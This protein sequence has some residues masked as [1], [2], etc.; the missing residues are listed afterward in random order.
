MVCSL[1]SIYFGSPQLGIQ[2]KRLSK[3]L[4]Y[5]SREMLNFGFPEKGLGK[6][7]PPHFVYDFSREMFF[8]LYSLN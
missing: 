4:G 3:T 1:V 2:Q 8:M 6:V 7:S 5:R